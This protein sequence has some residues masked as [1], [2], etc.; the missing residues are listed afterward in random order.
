[1]TTGAENRLYNCTEQLNV[2]DTNDYENSKITEFENS[3]L[4]DLNE[5][6]GNCQG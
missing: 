5:K 1:M 3:A 6:V 4:F 2:I